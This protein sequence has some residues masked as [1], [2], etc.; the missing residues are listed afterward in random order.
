MLSQ[1]SSEPAAGAPERDA[2]ANAR[3]LRGLELLEAG[4]SAN[5]RNAVKCFDDAIALRTT[6]PLAENCWYRYGLIAGWMNKGDALTRLGSPDELREAVRCYDEAFLHL[7]ELPMHESPLFIKRL[8]IAWL[9]RGFTLMKQTTPPSVALA[10]ES[11]REAIAAARHFSSHKPVE[12]LPLLAGAWMNHGN[13]LIHLAPPEAGMAGSSATEAL[14]LCRDTERDDATLAGIAFKARHILCQSLAHQ[15]ARAEVPSAQ[16]DRILA[17]A[18]DIVDDGMALARTWGRRGAKQFQSSAASLFRFG[19]RIYQ[20]HQPHF[21][22]EFLL[23][24]LDP[25][26]ADGAFADHP[27]MHASA[28]DS[29]W[30]SLGEFQRDGFKAINTPRYE[31]MLDSL[32]ELRVTE[33]RLATLRQPGRRE[34]S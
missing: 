26:R 13:A 28:M 14:R 19:C 18:S 32:G 29:L 4:T 1:L 3:L 33:E 34:R 7:R 9:N 16:Q 31:R 21:L 6:L 12:G 10:V 11:F 20:I 27:A 24:N 30:R 17:E 5:L 22:T 23:E 25:E 15:L 8:A 2:R